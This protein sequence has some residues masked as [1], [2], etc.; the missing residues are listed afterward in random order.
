MR[1]I[2]V[3]LVLDGSVQRL[4]TRAEISHVQSLPLDRLA[5][6]DADTHLLQIETRSEIL[7]SVG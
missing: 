7:C 6:T 1:R 3:N 2:L 5:D 4:H